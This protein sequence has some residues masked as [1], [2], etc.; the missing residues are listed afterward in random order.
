MYD[1]D[2]LIW[3]TVTTEAMYECDV[4]IWKAVTTETVY[5]CD[6]LIWKTVT[7]EDMY[8]C[9]VLVWKTVT[10]ETMYECGVLVWKTVKTEAM[11]ECGVL[12][13]KTVTTEAIYEC[14]VL[15]WK[16]VTTEA[17]H[18]CDILAWKTVT[19]DANKTI[20]R[21]DLNVQ[22]AHD[23]ILHCT[24]YTLSRLIIVPAN[25]SVTV[26][27]V[28]HSYSPVLMFETGLCFDVF[29]VDLHVTL[30]RTD[31]GFWVGIL[32]HTMLLG[33]TGNRLI[34]LMKFMIMK[35]IVWTLCIN[36]LL[37]QLNEQ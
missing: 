17:M 31:G 19:A 18:A 15:V 8:E 11:Y 29:T 23:Y 1:C 6:V 14:G 5:E 22:V 27:R 20:N 36:H 2:V 24:R 35:A 12:V 10:T 28:I 32:E 26:R 30:Q 3:K 34:L 33:D 13:W 16:T 4:L 9:D 21:D 25:Q 37:K 7:T